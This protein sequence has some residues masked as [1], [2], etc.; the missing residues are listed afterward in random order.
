[1]NSGPPWPASG[2]PGGERGANDRRRTGRVDPGAPGPGGSL[3]P[4]PDMRMGAAALRAL[5][6]ENSLLEALR[7][8]HLEMGDVFQLR[9]GAFQPIV[10]A[11]PEA[12]H[13]LLVEARDRFSWRPVGDPVAQLLNRG[14]L[15]TDGEEHDELRR[16]LRPPLHKGRLEDYLPAMVRWT[17][18]VS[19]EWEAQRPL[20]LLTEMRKIALLILFDALY[21]YDFS[22]RLPELLPSIESLLAY[23][24]P[25]PWLLAPW[26]PRPGYGK[27]IGE[28]DKFLY[29]LIEERRAEWTA[30][31][32]MLSS[33][34]ADPSLST[35]RVRD[36]LLTIMIAGHD[37]STAQLAWTLILLAQHPEVYMRV[38]AEIDDVLGGEPPN[39]AGLEGLS[40]L[41]QVL[42]E[43]LRLYPPIHM[44]NR[45]AKDDMRFRGRWIPAGSRV[46]YSIYLT[47]RDPKHWP[48]PAT[49]DPTRFA[50]GA[51]GERPAYAYLPFGGGP[52]NCLGMAFARVEA[53]AV[54]GRLLQ[55]FEVGELLTP[56]RQ[57]MGA[58]LEPGPDVRMSV[59]PR[60]RPR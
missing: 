31:E 43:S 16:R 34:A 8:F 4:R 9:M 52:R 51:G 29:E 57:H 50:P 14:L 18:H 56:V 59:R 25:G 33:L 60:E 20:E 40:Y 15:V 24:S 55:R 6:K 47:H 44:G 12:S 7:A 53:K 39:A 3:P 35:A 22:A 54:L 37:T 41:D 17:D 30:G 27:A 1:M 19:D 45:I 32:D 46:V 5:V 13:F 42:A 36:Q 28:V 10:M 2:R 26:L 58:T 49:F 11:G 21:A 48:E 38:V 23:I